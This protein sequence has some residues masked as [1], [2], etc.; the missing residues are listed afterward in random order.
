MAKIFEPRWHAEEREARD[1]QRY[2]ELEFSDLDELLRIDRANLRDGLPLSSFGQRAIEV[3]ARLGVSDADRRAIEAQTRGEV[4]ASAGT[5]VV[6][7][8]PVAMR[9]PGSMAGGLGL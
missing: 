5:P 6:G 1:R 7:V 9:P 8:A 3:Y 4:A 2:W